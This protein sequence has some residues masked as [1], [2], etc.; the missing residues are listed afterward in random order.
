LAWARWDIPFPIPHTFHT[1]YPPSL[2]I[3]V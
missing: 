2:L 1:T 3:F